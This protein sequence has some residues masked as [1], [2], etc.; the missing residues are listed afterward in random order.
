MPRS[1][2]V[3]NSDTEASGSGSEA[4]VY[5]DVE[6]GMRRPVAGGTRSSGP[7]IT[8][9]VA[10]PSNPPQSVP[11]SV[12][13]A[14][15]GPSVPPADPVVVIPPAGA[16]IP[17][18]P[19]K[20]HGSKRLSVMPNP[21]SHD[22]P[23]FR[24][25]HLRQFLEDY[26]TSANNAG[27]SDAKKCEELVNYCSG[28][29]RDI[30]AEDIPE[31]ATKNWEGLKQRLFDLYDPKGGRHRYPQQ[32]LSEY[33]DKQRR[34]TTQNEFAEYRRGFSKIV[35]NLYPSQKLTQIERNRFF[36]RGIPATLQDVVMNQLMARTP[37]L[38]MEEDPPYEEVS[39]KKKYAELELDLDDDLQNDSDDEFDTDSDSE[40]DGSDSPEDSDDKYEHSRR[41]SRYKSSKKKKKTKLTSATST[42]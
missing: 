34:I 19:I 35:A 11:F 9:P 41:R 31:V 15:A 8:Y 42:E 33:V 2:R 1:L 38:S 40:S 22:A 4:E 3:A 28:A 12:N 17:P 16:A 23:R 37:T 14:N 27:W 6:Q 21:H 39:L 25:K 36:W 30:V 26:S 13:M 32:K 7:A 10:G 20:M 18:V 24:G 5:T 29:A